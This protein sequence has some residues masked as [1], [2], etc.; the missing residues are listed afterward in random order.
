MKKLILGLAILAT[1]SLAS[2]KKEG[3]A[4]E[5]KTKKENTEVKQEPKADVPAFDNEKVGEYIKSY[6]AYLEDYKKVV[7]SKDMTKFQT[8]AAKGQELANKA[9]ALTTEGLSEADAKKLND[10]MQEKA[11]ELQEL[12]KKMMQ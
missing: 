8:L 11:K 7:E 6:D 12:A 9:Q 1:L 3:A 5:E 2:C 10:Y 4:T